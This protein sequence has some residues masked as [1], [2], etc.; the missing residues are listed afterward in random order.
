MEPRSWHSG[1]VTWLMCC[2]LLMGAASVHAQDNQIAETIAAIKPAV[3]LISTADAKLNPLDSGS[4]FVIDRKGLVATCAHV[5]QDAAMVTVIMGD[6]RQLAAKIVGVDLEHDLA[7]LKLPDRTPCTPVQRSS[8]DLVEG[9]SVLATG[10]PFGNDLGDAGLDLAA[11]T[12]RGMITAIRKAKGFVSGLPMELIQVDAK[13]NPGNSGGPVYY[14]E[15]GEIIGVV[16]GQIWAEYETGMNLAVPVSYL[17]DLL[18]EVREGRAP[19]PPEGKP[20][21]APRKYPTPEAIVRLAPTPVAELPLVEASLPGGG[22]PLRI[23]GGKMVSEAKRQRLYVCEADGNSLTIINTSDFS[24]VKRLAIGSRPV[25]VALSPD[26]S[27]LYVC[28]AGGSQLVVVDPEALTVKETLQLGFQPYDVVCVAPDKVYITGTGNDWAGLY[29]IN[30]VAATKLGVGCIYRDGLLTTMPGSSMVYAGQTHLSPASIRSCDVAAD[31]L[32]F[33]NA[34]E[35]PIGSNMQ[36]IRMSPDGRRVYV[37]CGAPYHVQV[38]DAHSLAPIGQLDTG[39]YPRHVAVSPD[40]S[41]VYA[42]HGGDHVDVFDATTFLRVGSIKVK[43][44]VSN[45]V[46]TDDGLLAL[47]FPNG[48]WLLD[49]EQTALEPAK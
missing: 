14:P 25:G 27:A 1:L 13:I 22:L 48:L 49:L 21:Q 44:E 3:V 38:L 7:I 45:M 2:S 15:S 35:G 4:G 33:I 46:V 39:P 34:V 12:T 32:S 17:L 43:G 9:R 36:D 16:A 5:L 37:C 29:L 28:L 24:V 10:Y 8:N 26:G 23:G 42:V 18:A 47:A 6:K 20:V 40:S 31:P 41:R 19:V 11:T 30:P